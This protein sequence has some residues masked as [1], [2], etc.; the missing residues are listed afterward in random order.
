MLFPCENIQGLILGFEICEDLWAP[1]SPSVDRAKAGATISCNLSA[2]NDLIGKDAYRRQLVTMQSAELLCGYI[3]SSC[4]EGESASDVVFGAHQM[5]AGNG[6]LLAER[7]F[8][9]G[10]LIS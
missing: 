1:E 10:L 8:Y 5:I 3:Y 2:S 4:G 6:T 9:G 7:R